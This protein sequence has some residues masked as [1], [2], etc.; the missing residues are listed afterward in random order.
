MLERREKRRR[1]PIG[2]F[3]LAALAVLV[4]VAA[5]IRFVLGLGATTNLSDIY[6]WGLWLAFDV[7]LIPF[8][9]GAFTLAATV[10]IFNLK[11]YRPVLRP[12]VL[13]GLLGYASVL[14]ILVIDLGRPDR[15]WHFLVFWNP[16]SPLFEVSWCI[17]LYTT[18]LVLEFSPSILERL[19]LEK[20]LRLVKALTIPLVI[21]GVTLSTLHQSSLGS[22]FLVMSTRLH[23]LWHTPF[24]PAFFLVSS[25]AGG[26][27]MVI[28][29][30]LISTKALQHGL[31]T[32]TLFGLAGALSYILGCGI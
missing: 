7:F 16:H 22:L 20:P 9:A 32:D 18:V 26:L 25:M 8:S 6:P 14:A 19:N 13:T 27:A 15:F 2:T 4:F 23:D 21:A 11:V 29:V 24:L 12:A 3:I 5:I 28:F 17:L 1:F 30:S 31:E 10:Y